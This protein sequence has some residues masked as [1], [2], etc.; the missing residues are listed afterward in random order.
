MVEFHFGRNWFF[1]LLV[2]F[3]SKLEHP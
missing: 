2:F 1:L 3:S